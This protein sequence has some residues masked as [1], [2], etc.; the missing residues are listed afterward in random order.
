MAPNEW[1][2]QRSK[3]PQV[4]I[5]IPQWWNNHI[6][7]T[8]PRKKKFATAEKMLLSTHHLLTWLKDDNTY[9]KATFFPNF[10]KCFLNEVMLRKLNTR[11]RNIV[12]RMIERHTGISFIASV[13]LHSKTAPQRSIND[14]SSKTLDSS[15]T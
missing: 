12:K 7:G 6:Q 9:M 8:P 2:M 15:S 13:D 4:N 10:K 14:P 5:V 11:S 1:N 3:Y